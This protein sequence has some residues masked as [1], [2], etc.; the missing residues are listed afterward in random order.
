[1]RVEELLDHDS[2]LEKGA[3][4]EDA[5]DDGDEREDTWPHGEKGERRR[6]EVD[7]GPT[8]NALD[9]VPAMTLNDVV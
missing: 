4:G 7:G 2:A 5:V 1:V 8:A 9:D 3:K 6:C